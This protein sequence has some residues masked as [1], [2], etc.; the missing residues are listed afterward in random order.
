MAEKYG[1]SEQ[2]FKIIQ[3]Q[4][5]RR[6]ELRREFLKQRTNPW[7]NAAEAGYV[8]DPALQKFMSMKVTQFDN[9]K[10]NR[11]TSMFGL[12]AVVIPM[13]VYGYFIWNDRNDREQ[14]IRSGELRYRDRMFK[15]V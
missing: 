7:K 11:S 13:F 2:E 5:N 6:A 3:Q 1:I 14:K 9:F 15:F 12:C 8:F 4:A 10:P